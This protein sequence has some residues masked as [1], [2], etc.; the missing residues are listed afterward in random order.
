[1]VKME[2]QR[3]GGWFFVFGQLEVELWAET[4]NGWGVVE[5]RFAEGRVVH[6]HWLHGV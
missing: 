5:S 1:M 2:R 3:S 4:E 6:S